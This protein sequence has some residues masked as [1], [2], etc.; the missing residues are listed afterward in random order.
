L[1]G[2]AAA[3]ASDA[4]SCQICAPANRSTTRQAA[5]NMAHERSS[6]LNSLTVLGTPAAVAVVDAAAAGGARSAA[7]P[8]GC[9]LGLPLPPPAASLACC[10]A[11][12]VDTGG[13]RLARGEAAARMAEGVT[14]LEALSRRPRLP[15]TRMDAA[16]TAPELVEEE[17]EEPEE[18]EEGPAG[19]A[20]GPGVDSM[21][22]KAGLVSLGLSSAR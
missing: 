13:G 14:S 21:Q 10:A 15:L 9:R 5:E 12:A 11:M 1:S 20:L 6:S 7:R 4:C 16:A 3:A 17:E 2:S 22:P 18:P 8:F 19:A